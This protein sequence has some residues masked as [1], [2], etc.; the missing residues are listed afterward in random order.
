ML[1]A[2]ML[3]FSATV[4]ADSG[5]ESND[6]LFCVSEIIRIVFVILIQVHLFMIVIRMWLNLNI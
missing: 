5:L 4:F 3:I 6:N 1:V 2:L